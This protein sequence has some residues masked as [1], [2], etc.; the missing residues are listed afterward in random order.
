MR[1][2]RVAC[3]L[4]TFAFTLPILAQEP[5]RGIGNRAAI[6]ASKAYAWLWANQTERDY[7][8]DV[9][10]IYDFLMRKYQLPEPQVVTNFRNDVRNGRYNKYGFAPLLHVLSPG[11]GVKPDPASPHTSKIDN[12][13][14]GT[15]WC[16]RQEPGDNFLKQMADLAALGRYEL[17]HVYLSLQILKENNCPFQVKHASRLAELETKLAEETRKVADQ[18]REISDLEVEAA[19]FYAFANRG[20]APSEAFL[21]RLI[22]AAEPAFADKTKPKLR[23]H[24]VVLLLWFLFEYLAPE[25]PPVPLS[26]SVR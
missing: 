8:V 21:K 5:D 22:A 23:G 24:T 16:D 1:M 17:T 2:P 14:F 9:V 15:L 3:F 26:G 10:W 18:S 12:V 19:A 13:T 11:A 6:V 25:T 20:K 7:Q 4:F